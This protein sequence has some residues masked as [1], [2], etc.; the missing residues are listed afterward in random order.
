MRFNDINVFNFSIS[1]YNRTISSAKHTSFCVF[2]S[3]ANAFCTSIEL[4]QCMLL[5]CVN[6]CITELGTL[7]FVWNCFAFPKSPK[8]TLL[9]HFASLNSACVYMT[10]GNIVFMV[11]LMAD[12]SVHEV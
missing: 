4:N 9:P 2:I 8:H 7:R 1:N 5:W 11:M 10:S 6:M 3:H 12:E